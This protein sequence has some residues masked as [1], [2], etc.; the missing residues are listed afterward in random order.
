MYFLVAGTHVML[1]D[2]YYSL[3]YVAIFGGL[4][5]AQGEREEHRIVQ[6][7]DIN[8]PTGLYR[9]NLYFNPIGS[10]LESVVDYRYID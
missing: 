10:K 7:I 2:Q 1:A 4:Q 9:I 3:W 6:I 5:I 8:C